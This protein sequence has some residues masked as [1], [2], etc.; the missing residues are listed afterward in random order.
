ML[1]GP[2]DP[3]AQIAYIAAG[4][5]VQLA[6][7]WGLDWMAAADKGRRAAR[8]AAAASGTAAT[9]PSAGAASAGF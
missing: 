6:L 2:L 3:S 7:A 8:P 4:L 1:T 9:A 5:A